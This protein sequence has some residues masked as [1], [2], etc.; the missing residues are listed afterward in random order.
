MEILGNVL[1]REVLL[2]V[3]SPS[4]HALVSAFCGQ[5]SEAVWVVGSLVGLVGSGFFARS[6]SMLLGAAEGVRS[7]V[8]ALFALD[9]APLR[10][11][12]SAYRARARIEAGGLPSS[13]FALWASSRLLCFIV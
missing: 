13:F 3:L 10:A 5:I 6:S 7:E 4:H 2:D 1:D 11:Q 12:Y 8:I 9:K